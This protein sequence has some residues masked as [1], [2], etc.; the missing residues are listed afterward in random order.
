VEP[1]VISEILGKSMDAGCIGD[2]EMD[3]VTF[4]RWELVGDVVI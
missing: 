2:S 4:G 3:E 1:R